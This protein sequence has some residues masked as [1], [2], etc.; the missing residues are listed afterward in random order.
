MAQIKALLD[1]YGVIYEANKRL[2]DDD[3]RLQLVEA[4]AELEDNNCYVRHSFPKT[5]LHKIKGI[6][7]AIYRAYIYKTSGWRIHLQLDD[8]THQIHLKEI[9]EGQL[10]DDVIKVVKASKGRYV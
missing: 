1:E 2:P 9:V 4:L 6:K 7:Q 5:Q 3:H 10:H 8:R